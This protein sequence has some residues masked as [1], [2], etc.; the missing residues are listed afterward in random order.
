M[1]VR[2]VKGNQAAPP[3]VMDQEHFVTLPLGALRICHYVYVTH[4][5]AI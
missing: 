4:L 1:S 2:I 3:P 5:A